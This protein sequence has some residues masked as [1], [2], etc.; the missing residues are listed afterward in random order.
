M[1]KVAL[2]DE[3][4]IMPAQPPLVAN[5]DLSRGARFQATLLEKGKAPL[6]HE[7]PCT[8]RTDVGTSA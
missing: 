3:S 2:L 6:M 5:Y 7:S 4:T 8:L 1:A